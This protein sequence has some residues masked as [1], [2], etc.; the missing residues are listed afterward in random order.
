MEGRCHHGGAGG[1]TDVRFTANG[2]KEKGRANESCD[3]HHQYHVN[4]HPDATDH[5]QAGVFEHGHD[6]HLQAN[7]GNEDKDANRA[8]LRGSGTF[9]LSCL[10]E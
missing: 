3:D 10:G 4:E 7:G 6:V 1:S 8:N 2:E 5:E 9:Q